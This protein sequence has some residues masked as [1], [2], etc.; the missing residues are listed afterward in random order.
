MNIWRSLR[1]FVV[2]IKPIFFTDYS[3]VDPETEPF[4]QTHIRY[5][6]VERPS[7]TKEKDGVP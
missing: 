4:L 3:L 7:T 1:P 2:F 5:E 6:E